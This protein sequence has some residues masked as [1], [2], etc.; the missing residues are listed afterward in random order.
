MPSVDLIAGLIVFCAVAW[1]L[2]AGVS[3][4]LP[5][6]AFAAAGLVAAYL[7]PLLLDDGREDAFAFAVALPAGLIAGAVAAAVVERF[8][9]RWRR[10]L[11][12]LPRELDIVLGGLLAAWVGL[13]VVWIAAAGVTQ[14]NA[15]D[16]EVGDSEVVARLDSTLELP[17]RRATEGE[18]ASAFPVIRGPGP[19]I[20]RPNRDVPD[21]EAVKRADKS[22]V[23]VGVEGCGGGGSGSGWIAADGVVVTNAHVTAGADLVVV[24]LRGEKEAHSADVVWFDPR[25]DLSLLR[26]DGIKGKPA[27]EIVRRPKPGTS[28]A[29]IG[30]PLGRHAIREARLGET[31]STYRIQ[32]GNAYDEG[33]SDSLNGILTT[34][35][36][37]FVEAGNSGG[38]V[39]DT[40][41][42]VLT[43]VSGG[44]D[45]SARGFG[46][47]NRRVLA[48]LRSAGEKKVGVGRCERRRE[49]RRPL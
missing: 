24:Q 27:L 29:V 16:D 8:A 48:A 32:I 23:Q 47:P 26:V 45:E 49:G 5:V 40:Q 20:A 44:S 10:R 14:I 19:E 2:W 25:H 7:A 28:G 42:R 6:A 17:G 30:Y 36:R 37:G 33:F 18:L 9:L 11:D 3:R 13:V 43:T 46:V 31:S 21:Y 12:A 34:F 15:L 35:F 1:G 39:V 22:V 41:G 4:A 38:P